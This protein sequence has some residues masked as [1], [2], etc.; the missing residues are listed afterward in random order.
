MKNVLLQ[1]LCV[2]ICGLAGC[3]SPPLRYHT[4][5]ASSVDALAP[6]AP[7]AAFAIDVQPV[8][9]PEQ[10][11]QRRLV[12][13]QGSGGLAVLEGDRW[14]GSLG[15]ELR[16]A[17]SLALSRRLGALD[18]AGL[19]APA[20]RPVIRVKV[21]LRRLDAWPGDRAQLEADWGLAPSGEAA[22]RSV[23]HSALEEATPGGLDET[24]RGQQRLVARLAEQI[25][26]AAE[27]ADHACG[28]P[29]PA[30]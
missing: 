17:L 14:G 22:P 2:A 6:A 10:L 29:A 18:V 23:C 8:G 11:D 9:V 15:D 25:A 20:G 26:Q 5:V 1:A 28:V 21:Q 24:V 12:I 30:R 13:R 4:L 27:R 19:S 16:S 7:A 3:A